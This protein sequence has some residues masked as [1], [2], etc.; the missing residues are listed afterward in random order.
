MKIYHRTLK[1]SMRCAKKFFYLFWRRQLA[2]CQCLKYASYRGSLGE[3]SCPR[4][5]TASHSV[6]VDRTLNPPI[7]RRTSHRRPNEMF[8]AN[9]CVRKCYDV[10]LGR[11]WETKDTR[12]R[13]KLVL[14]IYRGFMQTFIRFWEQTQY[15]L[16][17]TG[18]LTLL[19]CD[20]VSSLSFVKRTFDWDDWN[21]V[22]WRGR[23][24][25]WGTIGPQ[26]SMPVNRG[27][28][29]FFL[30]PWKNVLNVV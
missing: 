19:V 21:G 15:K 20:R 25:D 23:C 9:A 1:N 17:T 29:K 26:I 16:K 28:R 22:V 3:R 27:R 6:A 24:R 12:K 11:Y 2:A 30:S 8:V 5:T 14:T 13:I 18:A 7:E 10:E 4:S